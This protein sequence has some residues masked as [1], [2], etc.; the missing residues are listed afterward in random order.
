MKATLRTRS[1]VPLAL[2]AALAGALAL[3][4]CSERV[5][6][7][8]PPAPVPTPSPTPT[9][10]A[11]NWMQAPITP[12]DWQWGMNNGRSTATFAGN[13][14]VMRCDRTAGTVS[15]IRRGEASAAVPMTVRTDKAVRAFSANPQADGLTV[16]LPARDPLLDAMA[17]SRGRFA[18]ETAGVATL[19]IPSWT[20]VSRVIEDCR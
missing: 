7:P 16:A 12:G 9:T 19:Y 1:F 15:L 13:L 5:V 11:V 2:S 17:F 8:P 4:A 3:G 10:P 18:V 20:E 6:P 14:F